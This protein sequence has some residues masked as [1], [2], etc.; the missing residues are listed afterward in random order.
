MFL[1]NVVDY[2]HGNTCNVERVARVSLAAS[3]VLLAKTQISNI[4]F[5]SNQSRAL[6]CISGVDELELDESW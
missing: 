4:T 3:D 5:F 6:M 2:H 1:E